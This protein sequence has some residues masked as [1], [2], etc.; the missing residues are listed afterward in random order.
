MSM[1]LDE[2]VSIY[3]ASRQDAKPPS[4]EELCTDCPELLDEL[5]KRIAA[6]TATL[7]GAPPPVAGDAATLAPAAPET[8]SDAVVPGYEILGELGRGG[9]GVVYKARQHRPNRV[10]ALKMILAGGHSGAADRARFLAEAE[11]IAKLRHANI[12]QVYEVGQCDG[13]PYFSLEFCNGGNLARKLDGTPLPARAAAELVETLARAVQAAHAANVVHRDLKPA[14]I[15]LLADGTPKVTDFGLAKQSGSDLTATGAVMGTPSYMAPEQ[16]E[17]KKEVGPLADVY[18]LGAILY[19]CLTGRPPFRAATPL[20]TML[21]VVSVEPVAPRQLNPEVP[22]DLETICLKCLQKGPLRRYATASALADDL[23]RFLKGEP[24]LARPVGR[25]EQTVKWIR[26]NP[27]MAAFLATLVLGIALT[28][29]FAIRSERAA[30]DAKQQL[31]MAREHLMTSQ[32]MRVE[33]L[34]ETDPVLALELLDDRESCPP[35]LR[36]SA[37]RFYNRACLSRSTTATQDSPAISPDGTTRASFGS[38]PHVHDV[39]TGKEIVLSRFTNEAVTPD[40]RLRALAGSDGTVKVFDNKTQQERFSFAAHSNPVKEVAFSPDGNTLA[41]ICGF[42]RPFVTKYQGELDT[43]FEYRT[44]GGGSE[45]WTEVKL[46]DVL[47]GRAQPIFNVRM[48]GYGYV[49]FGPSGKT[50]IYDNG[51]EVIF[52]DISPRQTRNTLRGHVGRVNP[53]AFSPTADTLASGGEDHSI[54][55]WDAATLRLKLNLLGHTGAVTSLAYSPNGKILAS[56]SADG[57]VKFWDPESG[58]EI[59]TLAHWTAVDA[60]AFHPSG[61]MLASSSSTHSVEGRGSAAQL[62]IWDVDTTSEKA[63]Y[64]GMGG[65]FVAFS[66]DGKV[67][68]AG[69]SKLMRV[70][71]GMGSVAGL[72]DTN[73]GHENAALHCGQSSIRALAFRNGGDILALSGGEPTQEGTSSGSDYF[74]REVMLWNANDATRLDILSGHTN[75]VPCLAFSRDGTTLATGSTDRTVKLWNI[76]TGKVR[77]TLKGHSDAVLTLAFNSD[78]Q[79]LA[80]GSA[81]GTVILWDLKKESEQS[82]RNRTQTRLDVLSSK[83]SGNLWSAKSVIYDVYKIVFKV[84]YGGYQAYLLLLPGFFVVI[85]FVRRSRPIS[86]LAL[87]LVILIGVYFTALFNKPTTQIQSFRTF[88]LLW[89]I[90]AV[91]AVSVAIRSF[92]STRTR[93]SLDRRR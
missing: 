34:I 59:A 25:I 16:A 33:A 43:R 37:Y 51:K 9:M 21:Q 93:P 56:G 2:L 47:A 23:Q 6:M 13:Q 75:S 57:T 28:A 24:I 60:L 10:V 18:A 29:G 78:D 52:W 84:T 85:G 39:K 88:G 74:A 79:L 68:A 32:L 12:V 82:I 89:T 8:S 26:R 91:S 4:V 73:T 19:E 54:K 86:I 45:P 58:R 81:D 61:K 20:D 48:N 66:P 65:H 76:H 30:S 5:R 1:R 3:L 87:V 77:A 31:L 27:A 41:T 46:W 64:E 83:S 44:T 14:N 40:V 62:R 15:L 72:F 92:S 42:R 7:D 69:G 36:D 17:G 38:G 11:A 55:L 22:R 63:T 90:A 49:G 35:D 53:V 70:G 71:I 80:T 67:L 50:L